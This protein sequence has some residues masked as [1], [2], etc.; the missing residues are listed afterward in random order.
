M[1]V[2]FSMDRKSLFFSNDIKIEMLIC[3]SSLNSQIIPLL[4]L[5]LVTVKPC[6]VS[7]A[8]LPPFELHTC[9]PF[10]D[11]EPC[12][13]AG[14]VQRHTPARAHPELGAHGEGLLVAEPV[15]DLLW[16]WHLVCLSKSSPQA[17]EVGLLLH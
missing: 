4:N 8:H 3:G 2:L 17:L 16:G 6:C 1:G 11:T 14:R 12:D 7:V 10:T 5:S 9:S 15:L 13:F